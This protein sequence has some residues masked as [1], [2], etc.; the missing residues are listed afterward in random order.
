[1]K[2]KFNEVINFI[3]NSLG[4]FFIL[5]IPIELYYYNYHLQPEI[6]LLKFIIYAISGIAFIVTGGLISVHKKDLFLSMC[7][8]I[9]SFAAYLLYTLTHAPIQIVLSAL[10]TFLSII[11]FAISKK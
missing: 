4:L 1:M 11:V 7:L 8:L 9:L 10:L 2:T 3:S 5:M 6:T